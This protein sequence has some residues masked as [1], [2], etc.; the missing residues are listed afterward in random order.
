[1]ASAISGWA[2]AEWS[3]H[4]LTISPVPMLSSCHGLQEGGRGKPT[5]LSNIYVIPIHL[6]CLLQAL[7]VQ[8]PS[9]HCAMCG[10]ARRVCWSWVG[11][12]QTSQTA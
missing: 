12:S 2:A 8:P 7:T 10:G 11:R 9:S 3:R 6:P 4:L 5:G 1:M